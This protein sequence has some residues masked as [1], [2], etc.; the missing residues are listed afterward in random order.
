MAQPEPSPWEQLTEM[1][2]RSPWVRRFESVRRYLAA[3]LLLF[4]VGSAAAFA[5][6]PAVVADMERKQPEFARLVMLAPAEGFMVRIKVALALGAAIAIPAVMFGVW[7]VVTRGWPWGKRLSRFLFIPASL[8]L[9][10][11]GAYFAYGWV[12]PPALR[13]LL[14]FARDRL[15]PMISINSYTNFI[16]TMV[17]PFGLVF[18][19]P[20]LVFFLARL[21]VVSHRGLAQR[22]SYAIVG[23]AALAAALTPGPD[24]FSQL[25][26]AVPLVVL[27]EVSIWIAWL[28]AP[29]GSARP[30]PTDRV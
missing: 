22:R 2:A 13:F 11:G 1:L 28:A 12:V 7:A 3:G 6:A 27:Y 30:S 20:L 24:V 19:L 5:V 14:G 8:G 26:M 9:F 10:F 29:R 25:L 15:Q 23:I 18:Q 16:L 4:A 17:V 21:G